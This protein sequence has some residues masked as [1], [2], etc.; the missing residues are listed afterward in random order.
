MTVKELKT[1]LENV[2]DNL[3]VANSFDYNQEIKEAKFSFD[4]DR[5][6]W[7]SPDQLNKSIE[8]LNQP[9]LSVYDRS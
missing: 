9:E 4:R 1:L 6:G 2:D 5:E 3:V 7:I 8:R